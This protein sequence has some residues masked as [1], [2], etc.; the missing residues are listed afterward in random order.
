M[1]LAATQVVTSLSGLGCQGYDCSGSCHADAVA[2]TFGGAARA[3]PESF[4]PASP[5]RGETTR[6][7]Y[8]LIAKL[9]IDPH[10]NSGSYVTGG[11]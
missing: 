9:P 8:R 11:L 10:Q 3:V 7:R 6:T 4:R 2:A 5:S 1:D